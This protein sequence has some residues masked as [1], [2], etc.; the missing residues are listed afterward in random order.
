MSEITETILYIILVFS[1]QLIFYV[2]FLRPKILS[3]GASDDE[4]KKPL[5]GDDLAPYISAT[6]AITINA[7][8][9]RVWGWVI[10]LG[11]DR[12]GFFSYALLEKALGYEMCEPGSVPKFQD[13]EVGRIVPAS[14]DDSKSLIKFNFPVVAVNSGESFVLE[15]WGTFVLKEIAPTQTRLMVRTH[16]QETPNLLKKVDEFVSEALHYIMERRMLLGFKAQSEDGKPLSPMVDNLWL[17]GVVLS[18]AGVFL[19]I[20]ISAGFLGGLLAVV[21][22]MVWLWV[23][24]IWDPR[25]VYSLGFL[26]VL[27]VTAVWL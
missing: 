1:L 7:P 20:F 19:M 17:L 25:P 2:I 5:P 15:N 27:V 4:A 21:F 14:L 22:G 6:R 26:M 9:S 3:W 16:G 18:A 8:I 24:L 11:A 10:Q 13:M 12:G 23:L